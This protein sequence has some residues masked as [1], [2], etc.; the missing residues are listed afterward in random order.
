MQTQRT[1][2]CGQNGHDRY[3]R[4]CRKRG[5]TLE[6]I[7]EKSCWST[8]EK[9]VIVSVRVEFQETGLQRRVK[10]TGGK[11]NSAKRVWEI[12]NDLAMAL[13]LK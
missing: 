13:G 12:H 9:T 6:I 7:V 2:L 5:A 4:Q 10:P 1:L 3:G 11:W 8:S